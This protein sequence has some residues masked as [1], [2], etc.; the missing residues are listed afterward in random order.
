MESTLGKLDFAKHQ[1]IRK[2]EYVYQK[3]GPLPDGIVYEDVMAALVRVFRLS[4][5]INN[6][7][8]NDSEN[9]SIEYAQIIKDQ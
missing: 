4:Q 8:N 9:S 6:S 7:T 5:N 2:D 1:R 3:G